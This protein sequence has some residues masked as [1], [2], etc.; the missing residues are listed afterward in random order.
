MAFGHELVLGSTALGLGA[1]GGKQVTEAG[2]ATLEL[3][4]GG[5]LEALGDGLL[6]LLH[7]GKVRTQRPALALARVNLEGSC[8]ILPSGCFAPFDEY[9]LMTAFASLPSPRLLL[10]LPFLLVAAA[11]PAAEIVL[12]DP[13][14]GKINASAVDQPRLYAVV[15]DPE[16]GGALVTWDNPYGA[17]DETVLIAA[18][19]D[20]G[21]S[22]VALSRIHATGDY[23]LPHLGLGPAD[24][25]GVFTE[26]GIGG[27]EVG[28][29]SR[30]FGIRVRSGPAP[31][32]GEMSES[33]FVPFGDFKFWVRREIGE[34]EYYSPIN[35]IGMPVIRQRRTQNLKSIHARRPTGRRWR[36]WRAISS[37][38]ARRSRP[39]TRRSS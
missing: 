25:L 10:A 15:S 20:T 1:L 39:R 2:R 36:A 34:M 3:T 27:S 14:Y 28:D 26:I 7:G 29:V 8:R 4:F 24:Y 9:C 11:A 35:L 23:D 38:P 30:P 5:E 12:T 18:Y 16:A 21:A 22:G 32:S 37:P 31:E 6:G 13:G 19:I 17:P 33:D